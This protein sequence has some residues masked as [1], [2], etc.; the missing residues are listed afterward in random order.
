MGER[1]EPLDSILEGIAGLRALTYREQAREVLREAALMR[2]AGF[3]YVVRMAHLGWWAGGGKGM[4]PIKS[5]DLS[6]REG[7]LM[8]DWLH[9][10]YVI[11]HAYAV[12]MEQLTTPQKPLKKSEAN[13]GVTLRKTATRLWRGQTTKAEFIDAFWFGVERGLWRAALDGIG[14]L[15]FAEDELSPTESAKLISIINAMRPSIS[16]LADWIEENSQVNGGKFLAVINRVTQNWV[17][18]YQQIYQQ[19]QALVGRDLK[20]MWHLGIAEHCKSCLKLAGKI[21]RWSWWNENGILP[22]VPG[23]EYLEC[24]GYR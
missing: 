19:A 4:L 12:L 20:A 23:A 16:G 2:G 3:T 21:R 1:V 15:G 24:R 9:E 8:E 13:F 5:M 17:N 14:S 6:R 11:G 10:A 22:R 7:Q 18:R